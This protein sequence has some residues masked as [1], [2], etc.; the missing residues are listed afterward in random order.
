MSQ[1]K[2]ADLELYY[3]LP[4]SVQRECFRQLFENTRNLQAQFDQLVKDIQSANS[5]TELQS[6]VLTYD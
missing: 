2:V 1:P 5:L 3:H 6:K 4:E